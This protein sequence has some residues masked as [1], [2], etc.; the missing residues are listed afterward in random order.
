MLKNGFYFFVSIVFLVS[1]KK[2]EFNQSEVADYEIDGV[3]NVQPISVGKEARVVSRAL[4]QNLPNATVYGV[5]F[6]NGSSG[7]AILNHNIRDNP[8]YK[9]K[10]ILQMIQLPQVLKLR[11]VNLQGVGGLFLNTDPGFFVGYDSYGVIYLCGE[12]A[13]LDDTCT[14]RISNGALA[15]PNPII[16]KKKFVA[17]KRDGEYPVVVEYSPEAQNIIAPQSN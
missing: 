16:I 4:S 1:C 6:S 12:L 10:S 9:N 14:L 17:R 13:P 2:R 15:N 8:K 5:G 11:R 7:V 3:S